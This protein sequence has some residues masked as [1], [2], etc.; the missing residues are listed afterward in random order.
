MH[1]DFNG[2]L[3]NIQYNIATYKNIIESDYVLV[4]LIDP[5]KVVEYPGFNVPLEDGFKDVSPIGIF[6]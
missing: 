1:G 2:A 6:S 5:D 3:R 4:L